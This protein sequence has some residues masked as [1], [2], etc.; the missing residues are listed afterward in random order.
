MWK[1]PESRNAWLIASEMPPRSPVMSALAMAPVWPGSASTTRRPM[2]WR[3]RATA[4]LTRR[5]ERRLDRARHQLRRGGGVADGAQ[6][7]E[8][9]RAGEIVVAGQRR[10]RRR[11]QRGLEADGVAGLERGRLGHGAHAHAIG[12]LV[13]LVLLQRRHADGQALALAGARLDQLD[14]AIDVDGPDLLLAAPARARPR[15]AA[16]PRQ[17]R[18]PSPAAHPSSGPQSR[19]APRSRCTASAATT[20]SMAATV[21]GS[22][23]SRK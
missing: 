15:C 6:A 3:S 17:C 7:L 9:R 12:P 11:A 5:R 22:T 1:R 14:K 19:P 23:G 2:A 20:G 16:W 8:P 21:Q 18:A 10:P 13:R 4:A